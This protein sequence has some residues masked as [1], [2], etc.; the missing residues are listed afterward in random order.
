MD[1]QPNQLA[2][3]LFEKAIADREALGIQFESVSG[4]RVL[5]FAV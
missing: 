5:D 4:A 2:H 3:Q 1:H